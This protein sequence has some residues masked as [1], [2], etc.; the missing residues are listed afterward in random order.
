[1]GH[2]L[3]KITRCGQEQDVTRENGMEGDGQFYWSDLIF[4]HGSKSVCQGELQLSRASRS[5]QSTWLAVAVTGAC[6]AAGVGISLPKSHSLLECRAIAGA[7]PHGAGLWQMGSSGHLWLL[8]WAPSQPQGEQGC[9]QGTAH[10]AM[11]PTR[12][13]RKEKLEKAFLGICLDGLLFQ[14]AV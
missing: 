4:N 10:P 11:L 2:V 9:W 6:L 8:T 13:T 14:K 5:W 1:M 3:L 7:K 12:L